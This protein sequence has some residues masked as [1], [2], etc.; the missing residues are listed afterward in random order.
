GA[1]EAGRRQQV[2]QLAADLHQPEHRREVRHRQLA[3]AVDVEAP[4]VQLHGCH[5]SE[6][7]MGLGSDGL[8]AVAQAL[9]D[10]RVA[11]AFPVGQPGGGNGPPVGA[12]ADAGV[13]VTRV[14]LLADL[15]PRYDIAQGAQRFDLLVQQVADA[16]VGGQV[17]QEAPVGRSGDAQ[18]L[19]A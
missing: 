11:T 15:A 10:G 7:A 1:L 8:H 19:G 17:I 9:G 4:G 13:A 5:A 14:A 18:L 16:F 2:E 6:K 12:E 3:A